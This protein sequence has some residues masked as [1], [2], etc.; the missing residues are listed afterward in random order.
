[1]ESSTALRFADQAVHP[2][3]HARSPLRAP[4][5]RK[6]HTAWARHADEV[7]AAQRLR[8][9]IF[10]DEMGAQLRVPAGTAPGLDVDAFDAHC[11]H[12]LVIAEEND[13]TAAEVVG[14]YRVLTPAGARRA[15]GLYSETEFDLQ[16]LRS[17]RPRLA[18]LGRSCT[19]PAWRQGGVILMLWTSLAEFMQRNGLSVMMGCA[20][21]PMRDGGHGAASLWEA[22]RERH[23]A[24]PAW[25]VKPHLP[26]PVQELDRSLS[27]ET[28]P[29]IKG[30]LRCGAQL[31]GPPAWDPDFGVAD[32]PMMLDLQRLSEPYRAR[33]TKA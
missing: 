30:Y 4:Q 32:L 7:C 33:F 10:A 17:L 3:S 15:G 22:L 31:L 2:G 27:V 29:L 26:L 5:P 12:L 16:P 19:A 21:V 23:L 9:R 20:S 6:L 28:P 14:T 13:D 8:Y 25:R 11:E 24:E 1:M 18:E